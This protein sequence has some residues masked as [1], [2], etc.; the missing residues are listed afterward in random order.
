MSKLKSY[1][2]SSDYNLLADLLESGHDIVCE[3]IYYWGK[4]G[5]VRLKG[6]ENVTKDVCV[7]RFFGD[8]PFARYDVGSRGRCCFSVENRD[9]FIECCKEYDVRFIE[10]NKEREE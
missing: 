6:G 9:E 4:F 2:L 3:V 10:P 8:S 1:K 7:G 5:A